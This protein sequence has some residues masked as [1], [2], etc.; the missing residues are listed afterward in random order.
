MA[1]TKWSAEPRAVGARALRREDP[2]FL[3]GRGRYVSD[4]VLPGMLHAAFV[5]SHH[6]HARVL[7][8][9]AD[10][11]RALAG[12][13]AVLTVRDLDGLARPLRA[14][15]TSLGYREC[16]TEILARDKVRFA[17][18]LIALVLGES[19]YLAEDGAD[20]VH[21]EYE[22]LDAVLTLEQALADGAPAVH[23][24][25]P[26]NRFSSF[27]TETGDVAGAFAAADHVAE[28]ELRQQR[29]TAVALEGRTAVAA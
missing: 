4:V 3:T 25:V 7:D 15:K 19:R 12:V 9:D 13:V 1:T 23:D 5:R 11:A 20:A 8:I 6:A 16:D 27:E 29:Y 28:L 17:G 26:G 10:S 22:F 21:V 18:D 14:R 2:R 24:E